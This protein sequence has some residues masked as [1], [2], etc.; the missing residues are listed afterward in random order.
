MHQVEFRDRKE[1]KCLMIN[2]KDELRE[3]IRLEKNLWIKRNYPTTRP[4]HVRSKEL[5]FVS[6]LRHVE[7]YSDKRGIGKLG[8]VLLE[9]TI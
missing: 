5:L 7:Y 6:A 1:D 8:G 4:K 2:T 3:L 9:S